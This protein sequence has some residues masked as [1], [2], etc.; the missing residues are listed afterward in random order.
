MNTLILVQWS[1]EIPLEKMDDFVKFAKEKLEP[2]YESH[3]CKRFELFIPVETKKKYFRYQVTQKRN[4]YTEQ[5]IFNNLKSFED[6]LEA[7]EKDPRSKEIIDKY[8]KEFNVSDCTF[9]IST[10]KV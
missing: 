10:Q 9:E 8:G 6:F 1:C 3:D 5:L 7:V 4:R 2:F